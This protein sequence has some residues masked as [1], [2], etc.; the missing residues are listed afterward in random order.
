MN[1]LLID[2]HLLFR[3]GLRFL[4]AELDSGLSFLEAG[5]CVEASAYRGAP[6]DLVLLDLTLPGASGD[7]AIANV[8]AAFETV[9]QVI[10]SGDDE[11]ALV[12]RTIE[13]GAAGFIPKAS[14]PSVL[15]AALRRVLAGGVYLPPHA[16]R[17]WPAAGSALN[18]EPSRPLAE[19]F[20]GLSAQ[21]SEVLGLTVQGLA[22]ETI[23]REL[24]LPE[25]TVTAALSCALHALGVA[26]RT[27]AVYASARQG[28]TKSSRLSAH[29]R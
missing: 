28:V 21:Q 19:A 8:R 27:E 11:P 18:G 16:L 2:D 7:A 1:L 12:R 26:D 23:A 25:R 20:D 22:P 3:S 17:D 14:S 5:S 6:V 29:P 4:L 10:V 9:P 24:K 13:A 15:A